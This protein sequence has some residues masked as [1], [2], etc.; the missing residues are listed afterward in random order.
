[1]TS[2]FPPAGH[3]PPSI[4]ETIGVK[5]SQAR[6]LAKIEGN[7]EA[8]P[9]AIALSRGFPAEPA[10]VWLCPAFHAA[11]QEFFRKFQRTLKIEAWDLILKM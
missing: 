8:E 7:F 2:P 4:P 5:A 3:L 1:M 10:E 6:T 9:A 11:V